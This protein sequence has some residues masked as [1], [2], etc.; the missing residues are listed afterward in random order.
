[1]SGV[2]IA[3]G[4]AAVV[5][6]GAG[7]GGA[8]LQSSA[9][10]QAAAGSLSQL[11]IANWN[12][13]NNLKYLQELYAPFISAGTNALSVLTRRTYTAAERQASTSQQRISLE[14]KIAQLSKPTDWNTFPILVGE[15]ASERR[16]AL[17]HQTEHDRRQQLAAAQAELETFNKTQSDLAP[18]YAK[19]DEENDRRFSRISSS[20]DTIAKLSDI[21][22][23]LADIREE[24]Q[25]DPVYQFRVAEG[26]RALNRAAAAKGTFF[27]G[28][29]MKQLS[30]FS[31]ALTG[32]ETDKYINRRLVSL[33]AAVTGL[34]AELGEQGQ[35]VNQ[36]LSLAQLGLGAT[37]GVGA[38]TTGESQTQAQ[39][40]GGAAQTSAQT[41][42][43]QG[44]AAQAGL[45]SISNTAGSLA[46]L[47]LLTKGKA[48]TSTKPSGGTSWN[49]NP[50]NT[51]TW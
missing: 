32:E 35:S 41:A 25:N 2:A 5:G 36:A 51:F 44:A 18:V 43:A 4:G 47:T 12:A 10:K 33:Q 48:D 11:D 31:L 26:E 20:L 46:A 19:M 34:N 29:A 22:S 37:Q 39:L 45:G 23:S 16:A 49:N 6:A 1:M 28:A 14:S 50:A 9:A 27:S 24:L 42:L 38:A 7:I 13:Q 17:F 40:A 8:M 21:P 30:D 3:I 15:K